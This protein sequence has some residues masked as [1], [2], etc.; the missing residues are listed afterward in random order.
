[1]CRTGYCK[2]GSSRR[3]PLIADHYSGDAAP[4]L[5]GLGRAP[6][7]VTPVPKSGS[8]AIAPYPPSDYWGCA[9]A[10][11]LN[12]SFVS[13]LGCAALAVSPLGLDKPAPKANAS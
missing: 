4:C 10:T 5:L 2:R 3:H 12:D 7:F 8:P 1:M 9:L 6:K 11:E 13:W